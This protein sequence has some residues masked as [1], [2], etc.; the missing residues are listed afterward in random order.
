MLEDDPC[1]KAWMARGGSETAL[2]TLKRFHR[3]V[4][5]KHPRFGSMT[6][7]QIVDWQAKAQGREDPYEIKCLAQQYINAQNLRIKS[8]QTYLSHICSPFLHNH[9]PLPPDRSFRFTSEKPPVDGKLTFDGFRRILFNCNPRDRAIF[10]F[11]A[12][13]LMGENELIHVNIHYCDFILESLTKNV[14]IVKLGLPGRKQNRNVKNYYT[15]FHTR[16]DCGDALRQYLKH[17]PALPKDC[18]FK[19][20]KQKPITRENIRR[21]FHRHAVK[22]SVVKQVTPSCPKCGGETVRTRRM[23]D[24]K[25]S[26]GYICR[27]CGTLSWASNLQ[28]EYRGVRYGVNPHEIRDLMRSRWHVSG[29]DGDVA[30]FMLQHEIDENKYD[31]FMHL[32]P[33]YP[34][35]EYKKALGWLNILSEDPAKVDRGEIDSRLEERDVEID[36]LRRDLSDVKRKLALAHDGLEALENPKVLEAL[37]EQAKKKKGN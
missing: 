5:A 35:R 11:M 8:K 9:A 15:M 24:K 6:F 16:S 31:K 17:L 22:A 25:K 1:I 4:L 34:I 13:T 3:D 37:L 10:T 18:F 30:E 23:H 12:S 7:S 20:N 33:Q 21:C 19:N 27:E 2:S 14:G 36:A 26:V 29:A 32:E 28:W